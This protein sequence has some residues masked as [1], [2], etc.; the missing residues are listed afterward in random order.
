MNLVKRESSS[1]VNLRAIW[2]WPKWKEDGAWKSFSANWI[3]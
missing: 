3:Y 1:E 2:K